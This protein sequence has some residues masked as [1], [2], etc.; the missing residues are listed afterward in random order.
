MTRLQWLVAIPVVVAT[1][2]FAPASQAA[3]IRDTAGMFSKDVVKKARARLDRVESTTGIPIVIETIDEIPGL[4]KDASKQA[5]KKAIDALAIRRDAE[6]R[7]EGIYILMSKRDHAISHVLV[8]ERLG[9]VLPIEKRDD[10]RNALVEEFN[11]RKFDAGL[12]R[13]VETI[14]RSLEGASVG[15]GGAHRARAAAPVPLHEPADGAKLKTAR[16]PMMTFLLIILGIF[17]VLLFLRLLGGLFGRGAGAGYQGQMGGMPRPG[18][19]PGP[20]Y[21]GAPGGGGG[22]FFSGLLGGLGGALAGNWLYDQFSGRHGHMTSAD[23]AYPSSPDDVASAP[24]TG[25]DAII[26]ADDDPGGG[27]I[28]DDAGGGNDAGAGDWGGDGG[29]W[30]GGGGDWGGGGGDWGGGGGGGGDW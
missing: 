23:A 30:G 3:A 2:L 27:A 5:K 16:S 18:M 10:I 15:K 22:G 28:W 7:D 25:G 1:A 9:R 29:D 26:G 4:D 17:G 12:E 13:A 11:N 14:E 8:R 19:G 24:D 21:Y 20:G 6:I